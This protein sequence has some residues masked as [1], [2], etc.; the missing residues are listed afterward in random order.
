MSAWRE[1]AAQRLLWH[2]AGHLGHPRLQFLTLDV[3]D[4]PLGD[5]DRPMAEEASNLVQLQP[6][7]ETVGGRC[8]RTRLRL[9]RL[10]IGPTL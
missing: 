4:V 1:P 5:R 2:G 7:V 8:V 10:T 9:K 6:T 3:V